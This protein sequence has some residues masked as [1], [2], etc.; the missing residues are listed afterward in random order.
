MAFN[1]ADDCCPLSTCKH[2]D[3]ADLLDEWM[4]KEAAAAEA[5][6]KAEAEVGLVFHCC[7]PFR[8][9]FP[10]SSLLCRCALSLFFP[11]LLFATFPLSFSVLLALLF[12]LLFR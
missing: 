10:V 8:S 11:T 5:A 12:A 2:E 4:T 9:V 3:I 1:I 7:V 6:K